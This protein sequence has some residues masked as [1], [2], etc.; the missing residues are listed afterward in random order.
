MMGWGGQ[1]GLRCGAK[2]PLV[3]GLVLPRLGS[4]QLGF[5]WLCHVPGPQT[6]V[7]GDLT[8]LSISD[9]ISEKGLGTRL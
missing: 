5:L 7:K 9:S 3:H 6:T 1:E 2:G 4:A 8:I